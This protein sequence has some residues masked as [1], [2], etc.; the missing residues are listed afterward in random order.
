MN[1]C[2]DLIVLSL[3]TLASC[4]TVAA[5][6]SFSL[7][8]EQNRVVEAER[9]PQPTQENKLSSEELADGWIL[10]FDGKSLYG[11]TPSTD[12]NWKVIDGV[13]TATK[14]TPGLLRTTSQFGNYILKVDFRKVKGGNSGVFLRT[15]P[16]GK[17]V[18]HKSYELNIAGLENGYPT[19]SFC[20]RQKAERVADSDKWQTFEVQADGGHFVVRLNGEVINDYTDPCPSGRGFIGLQFRKGRIQFRNVKLKPLGSKSIFNGKNLDGW[21]TYPDMASVVTV[22]P[23]G[24]LNIKGGKGQVETEGLY[25]DFDL[26]L[27]VYVNGKELNSGIFFRCIPGEVM[28]GY[29][30]QIHN[31]FKDGDRNRPSDSGTGG[32][33]RRQNA[34]FV[35]SNDFEWFTQTIHA[36]DN[37]IAVW[38]NGY[39]VTDWSDRRESD[40]NPRRGLRLEAGTIILQGHDPTMDVSF[41]NIRISEIPPRWPEKM[42][43]K[44]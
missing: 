8:D 30:S 29:E 44:K 34:R 41:R 6:G 7:A 25:D 24:E 22:T 2:K 40:S 5:F 3:L 28:N 17:N 38:V 37:H 26:Q 11:W 21:E 31:G 10:L 42:N 4:S 32:I 43:K 19:G 18:T 14:G 13:I 23:N 27:E 12:V 33:F 9:S 16:E 35:G 39:Q 20:G 1:S 36:D 15:T